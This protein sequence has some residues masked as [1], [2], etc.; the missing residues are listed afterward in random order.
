M[1]I[2]DIPIMILRFLTI[3]SVAILLCVLV[4]PFLALFICMSILAKLLDSLV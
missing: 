3:I 4:I 2:F 1:K